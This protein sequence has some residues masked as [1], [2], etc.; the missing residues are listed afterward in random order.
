M[1]NSSIIRTGHRR[2]PDVWEFRWREPG[3]G[4]AKIRWTED[5]DVFG[6]VRQPFFGSA[7]VAF[8]R[9]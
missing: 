9:R 3:P 2:G 6:T 5:T 1:Q 7:K 8:I 4:G